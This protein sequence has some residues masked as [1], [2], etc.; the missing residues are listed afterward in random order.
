MDDLK[1]CFAEV[2]NGWL[3]KATY[4]PM[5]YTLSLLLYGRKIAR[6]TGSRLMVSWSKQG[7][8]MYFMGKPIPMDAIR[9]MVD[10]IIT[11][12]KDIL[13]NKLM[14]KEGDDVRFTIPLAAIEDGL[15]QTQRGKSFVHSNGLAGKEVEMLENLVCGKR[16]EEFLDKGG[17][18]EEHQPRPERVHH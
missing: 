7:D 8:L 14:F 4:S 2:R 10:E 15:T 16:R 12:A 9:G 3:C 1:E 6:E 17:Q 18:C 11:D 13:W 5:G